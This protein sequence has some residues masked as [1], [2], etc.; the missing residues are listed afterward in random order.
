MSKYGYEELQMLYEA[1]PLANDTYGPNRSYPAT[2]DNKN[3]AWAQGFLQGGVPGNAG[4]AFSKNVTNSNS[5]FTSFS[6][7]EDE[8]VI[9]VAIIRDK[10]NDLLQDA[11]DPRVVGPLHELLQFI[12]PEK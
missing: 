12:S 11:S 8:R 3:S 5:A 10:I 7:D 9:A 1:Y 6:E 2:N 4:N